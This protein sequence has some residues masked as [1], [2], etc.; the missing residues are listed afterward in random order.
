MN[1][2][3]RS[4][5]N[6]R[7]WLR[8]ITIDYEWLWMIMNVHERSCVGRLTKVHEPSFERSWTFVSGTFE[9]PEL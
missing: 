7:E 8:M 1:V 5:V 4:L 2:H 6:V 9:W 3:S